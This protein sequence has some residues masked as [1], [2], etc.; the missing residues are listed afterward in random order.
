LPPAKSGKTG[1][2]A[3][4]ISQ[5][6]ETMA[7]QTAGDVIRRYLSDAIAAEKNF[8][9]QLRAMAKETDQGPVQQLFAQHADETRLQHERLTARLEALG[10][11]PSG[12]KAVLASLLGFGPKVAQIGHDEAEKGTQDLMIAHAVEHSEI[13]M[14]E[15]LAVAAETAG[16]TLTAQLAREIQ[17]E[18][19]RAAELVWSLLGPSARDS[20]LKVIGQG[21]ARA[22]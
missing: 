22:A 7:Q 18:E 12:F 15:A 10:G 4:L 8:E 20:F 13:A 14:Y 6:E 1:Q 5:E 11:E 2:D 19:R 3:N 21:M 9:T 16:D 17:Q